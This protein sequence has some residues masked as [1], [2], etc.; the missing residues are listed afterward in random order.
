M[1]I[2]YL[3][4]SSSGNATLI[5]YKNTSILIDVGTSYKKLKEANDNKDVQ[6][7]AVFITHEHSDHVEGAGVIG[8]K[9]KTIL[10][11]PELS[12]E[13][14]KSN[15]KGCK[16]NFVKGGEEYKIKDLTVKSFST[17]HD[18][19]ESLGYIVTSDD[20]KSYGHI[21]D[22]GVLTSMIIDAV[23]N[24]DALFIESDYDMYLLQAYEE[25]DDV[26]KMRIS[27]N[28]GHLSNQQVVAYFATEANFNKLQWAML[29]HLSTKTNS[30]MTLESL[31]VKYL[32]PQKAQK[33]SI[34]TDPI[35]KTI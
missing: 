5:N 17:R 12:Y 1:E 3:Y 7:D 8:R 28:T 9:S 19:L 29:G 21:T 32:E 34:F 26:L 35:T 18:S 4:S 33:I 27:S 30:K 24:C 25:Y 11:M 10:F 6:P 13:S 20:G 2:R 23:E 16:I 31:L 14:I 22:T 15:L